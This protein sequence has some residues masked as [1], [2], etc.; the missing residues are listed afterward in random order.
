MPRHQFS[1]APGSRSRLRSFLAWAFVFGAAGACSTP[2]VTDFDAALAG[3]FTPQA[4]VPKQMRFVPGGYYLRGAPPGDAAAKNRSDDEA[5]PGVHARPDESPGRRVGVSSFYLDETPVTYADFRPYVQ[6]AGS[7]RNHH[8]DYPIYNKPAQPVTG[9]NWYEAA[10]YCNWRSAAL[11]LTPAYTDTGA[12]DPYG[13]PIWK[14]ADDAEG[15]RL[16]T[17]AEFEYAAVARDARV[18]GVAPVYPWGDVFDR[19]LANY[20]E[21][22]GVPRG[23][24]W[25]L[26][27]VQDQHRNDLGLYGMSGNVWEWNDDWYAAE[28]YAEADDENPRGPQEPGRYVKS[29]RGGSW[30]GFRPEDLRIRRRSYSAPGAYHF[31]VGFRCLLPAASVS[32]LQ[33]AGGRGQLESAT[34]SENESTAQHPA[35]TAT[36]TP[37]PALCRQRV[38]SRAHSLQNSELNAIRDS[39]A[40]SA[41]RFGESFRRRLGEYL[42]DYFAESLYFHLAVDRQ[43]ILTP[44]QLADIITDGSLRHNIHPLFLTGIMRAESGMGTVS[45]PRWFNNPM[46]YHWQNVQMPNGLPQYRPGPGRNRK[47]RTLAEGFDAYAR[48]VRQRFYIE[49]ARGDL[50]RFHYIYVG[51]DAQEWMTALTTVYREVLG[52]NF[53][54]SYPERDCGRLIYLDWDEIR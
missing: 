34:A 30:G 16:P 22:R 21:G 46:A 43:K 52:V 19:R 42:A 49:A 3:V 24:W 29:M 44:R 7:K 2:V 54:K 4:G 48:G 25:R 18:D 6:A 26:S 45:F 23:R 38:E 51:Y 28:A 39:K 5:G 35:A 32:R 47:Y 33:S 12:Q 11:G 53:T 17:E 36:A 20:D 31:D 15:F 1:Y 8:W 14:R 10:C 9:L 27:R 13:Y 41:R 40:D 50:Y 37:L